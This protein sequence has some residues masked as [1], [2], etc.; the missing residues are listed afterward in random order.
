MKIKDLKTNRLTTPLGFQLGQPHLSF[1]V[2]ESAGT[3]LSAMQVQVALDAAMTDLVYDSGRNG[4]VDSVAFPLPLALQPCT[5][6]FWHV[7][8]R[9]DAGG[10][11]QSDVTWFETA[12]QDR[13]WQAQWI[14]PD[15]AKDV[16]ARV[17]TD[18]EVPA[19][20]TQ[21]RVYGVGLGVYE[22]YWDDKKL[23]DEVLLPG[24]HDYDSWIQYQTYA[25]A[26]PAPGR[27]QLSFLLGNGWYKGKFGLSRAT[28]VYG[29][30]MA[31]LA[32]IHLTG[33]DGQMVV[34]G[35]G[36]DWQAARSIVL[37]SSIYD[38]E[39]QD[40]T[41]DCS[42]T[43]GVSVLELGF[44]R[45][46]ARLSP[47]LVVH[48]RLKPV[49][50]IRT[51]AGESVLDLGQN[52]VG[53][54]SFKTR[55]P[56]GR[57]LVFQ[58]GE[59]LQ[60]GNFYRDN[61]RQA[62]ARFSYIADGQ[63][64]VVRPFFT[65]FGF[66]YVKVEGWEGPLDP[67][68]FTGCVI[69]SA[70][71]EIGS[72]E[73]S[74][75]RVNRLIANVR[76]GQKGNFLDV[77]TD[78]PQR[79]ERMGWTGDAQIFCETA[80]FN[81][82]TMAFYTKFAH[83]LAC[84]QAKF[85]GSVPHVVP[86]AGY[87]GHGSTAWGDAAAIIPWSVYTHFGDPAILRRQFASMKAW[88]DFIRRED[89]RHGGRRL[90]LSGYH[91]ADWLALDGK[92]KGGVYGGTDPH[93]VASAYYCWSADRVAR[94][95]EVL[96]ESADAAAYRQLAD[97]IRTAIRSE[98]ISP[99]GRLSVDTQTGH[100][101]TLYMDLAEEKD[102][103]RLADTLAEKIRANG[104]HLDTGF[105]GTPYLCQ[106]L[107]RYGHHDLAC[108]LLFNR[109]FPSWLYEVEMGATTI[110]ERWNSV[111]PD[112][113]ISSTGMNS[114]NHYAYGSILEWIYRT[115]VGINP[116]KAGFAQIRIAPKPDYRLEHV[117]GQVK[118]PYGI[119]R[120]GWTRS[121]DLLDVAVT[122]PF[123]TS[124]RLILPDA[125]AAAI[126]LQD[127]RTA[128]F[129]QNGSDAAADLLPGSARFSYRL[130]RPCRRVYSV[131]DDAAL[132]MSLPRTR[133]TVLHYFP[134]IEGPIPFKEESCRLIEIM[135]APFVRVPE[136]TIAALD[137]ALRAI[138]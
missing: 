87:T 24:L 95:A 135:Q 43:V 127:G 107:S 102:R 91:F 104:G 27:H 77:P 88:V 4:P 56:R 103:Q 80:S 110:W 78:C 62:K 136:A 96:G 68:D 72:A 3:K 8:A 42:E 115:L 15:F 38:G 120:S 134:E 5:R 108:T 70:M 22:L 126:D 111:L 60:D 46:A 94:A 54:L 61:L 118:T 10:E 51:P 57:Q 75:S 89:D 48:E 40:A 12:R 71:E 109:D 90:W 114:L 106:V 79:D 123:G 25:I 6:Y 133:E 101:V 11:A 45:L 83:D 117:R 44:D 66:R 76:W 67:D 31:C 23:G 58:F 13:L 74:D 85:G 49:A 131:Q 124:A 41:L 47:Q 7:W 2:T 97:E 9:D 69:H 17:F 125:D 128:S 52:M 65:F 98:Y 53:Q 1:V 112:G 33:A 37:S 92:V 39:E 63:D 138:D 59:I 116:E 19:G 16:H 28:E 64:A 29:D 99:A 129:C 121:G 20:T 35:T 81:M 86:T 14:T 93:F 100:A 30:R 113:K 18:L 130:T 122:V 137:T 34:L 84:E 32:E 36:P 119:C 21:I 50:V 55:A 132:L 26:D 73:T 105:V 82:D